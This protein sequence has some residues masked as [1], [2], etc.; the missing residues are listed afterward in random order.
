MN[1][2]GLFAAEDH[3]HAIR[4]LHDQERRI[5]AIDRAL[6]VAHRDLDEEIRH[7]QR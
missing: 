2:L 5:R 4:R 7:A 3:E 6:A 1:R